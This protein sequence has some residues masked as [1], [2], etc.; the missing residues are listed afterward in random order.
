M[1]S[2]S[3]PSPERTKSPGTTTSKLSMSPEPTWTTLGNDM[4]L[5]GVLLLV[6]MGNPGPQLSCHVSVSIL[7]G[8]LQQY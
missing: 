3:F 5:V 6:T 4:S 1:I 7:M 8:S 2:L